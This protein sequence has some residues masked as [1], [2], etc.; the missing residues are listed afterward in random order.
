MSLKTYSNPSLI[1]SQN[2]ND[3]L[4]PG[5]QCFHLNDA[6]SNGIVVAS[7]GID[8]V[9]VLW[10]RE[11]NIIDFSSFIKPLKRNVGYSS[12]AQ[13][14][15]KVQPTPGPAANIFYVENTYNFGS[16]DD[17]ENK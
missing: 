12:I 17:K 5:C 13:Q 3:E 6:N 10:S 11:P 4:I 2:F 8:N 15:F 14:I 9:M 7:N 1:K 16:K